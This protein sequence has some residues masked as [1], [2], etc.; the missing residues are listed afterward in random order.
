MHRL[1]S[2]QRDAFMDLLDT[3]NLEFFDYPTIALYT[4]WAKDPKD[5]EFYQFKIDFLTME[6][7][8]WVYELFESLAETNE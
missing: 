1:T 5:K 4:E 3:K 7:P 6:L 8:K 2:D